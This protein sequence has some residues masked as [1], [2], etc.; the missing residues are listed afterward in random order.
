MSKPK[1][2]SSKGF[3]IAAAVILITAGAITRFSISGNPQKSDKKTE[4]V[5]SVSRTESKA[6]TSSNASSNTTAY[7]KIDYSSDIS[8][9]EI[10]E[11][12]TD[13]KTDASDTGSSKE[14]DTAQ[15][16]GAKNYVSFALPLKGDI[17][18]QFDPE[19]LQYSETYGD[20]RLH[21]GIDI[22][23]EDGSPVKS[24][25]AGTVKSIEENALWGKVVTLDHGNGIISRYCGLSDTSVNEGDEVKLGKV[26]GTIG[27]APCE[28]LDESH[29]HFEIM[30]GDIYLSPLEAIGIG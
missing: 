4:S 8:S 11:N 21:N 26:I 30:N 13:T 29:L 24:A 19:R 5:S 15:T 2:K 12:S 7:P 3:Y 28:C 10:N 1:K 20:M 6:D 9:S 16:A 17:V 22:L 14:D 25:A 18:K 27:E 23:A